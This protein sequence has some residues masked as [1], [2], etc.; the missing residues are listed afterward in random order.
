MDAQDYARKSGPR[1]PP[2]SHPIF[3]RFQDPDVR[4]EG[5]MASYTCLDRWFWASNR[6]SEAPDDRL[7]GGS[8]G[9]PFEEPDVLGP[10]RV[11]KVS[12]EPETS[13]KA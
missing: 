3:A 12:T 5:V 9:E 11:E 13:L 6:P 1:S 7:Q 10:R 4:S 2:A 8:A